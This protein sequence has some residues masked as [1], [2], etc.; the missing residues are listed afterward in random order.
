V[1]A[2]AVVQELVMFTRFVS[3][4]TLVGVVIVVVIIV[5]AILAY[6]G[7]FESSVANPPT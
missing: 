5:L 1:R 2:S 4:V 7:Q 6:A 3:L